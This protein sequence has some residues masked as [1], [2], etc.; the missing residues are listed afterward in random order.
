MSEGDGDVF[1]DS[2]SRDTE[3]G[4]NVGVGHAVDTMAAEYAHRSLGGAGQRSGQPIEPL[5][6]GDRVECGGRI[7][8]RLH[9]DD[10]RRRVDIANVATLTTAIRTDTV[11]HDVH[12]DAVQ[13]R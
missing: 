2:A 12:A 8:D 3:F 4:G 13:I 11:E 5:A 10:R 1:F 6:A 7:V 9:T